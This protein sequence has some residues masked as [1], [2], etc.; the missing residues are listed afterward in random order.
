MLSLMTCLLQ[1]ECQLGPRG[2]GRRFPPFLLWQKKTSDE[3][4]KVDLS[5]VLLNPPGLSTAHTGQAR[6]SNS[7]GGMGAHTYSETVVECQELF[8]EPS[9][10]NT[11]YTRLRS[12]PSSPHCFLSVPGRRLFKSSTFQALP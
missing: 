10:H 7:R 1:Q 4:W 2:F 8:R 5:C 12:R 3:L 11:V 6:S 9:G